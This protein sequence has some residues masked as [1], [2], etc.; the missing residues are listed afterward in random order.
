MLS[1]QDEAFIRLAIERGALAP[2]AL[3]QLAGAPPSHQSAVQI[4]VDQGWLSSLE[5][6]G[7]LREVMSL[8]FGCPTCG[9]RTSHDG[10]ASR[11]SFACPCGGGLAPLPTQRTSSGSFPLPGPDA[12]RGPADSDFVRQAFGS[13]RF[14]APSELAPGQVL[15]GYH[16]QRELGRGA[17]GVVFLARR[18]GLE[19]EFAIKVLLDDT[20]PDAETIARFE[21]EAAIGSKLR[22]P[23]VIS[24]YDV[25]RIQDCLYYAMEYSPGQD[26]KAVLRERGR[27]PWEEGAE[28]CR[29]LA[30]TLAH[31]HDRSVIHRDLKP[32]NIIL[33]TELNRPRVTDFGLAR[34]RTL[35]QTMTATGDWL[36]TPYYMSPEQFRG[37]T[38]LDHRADIYALGTILFEVLT[39]ERPYV[40]K[41]AQELMELVLDGQPP[42]P[43]SRV[44]DLPVGLDHVVSRAMESDPE[45][46]YP[47]ARE[48]AADL[49]AVL[50]GRRLGPQRTRLAAG[51]FL[52]AAALFA[53]TAFVYS[54]RGRAAPPTPVASAPKPGASPKASPEPTPSTP[55]GY[56]WA[57]L[58]ADWKTWTGDLDL[59]GLRKVQP[60]LPAD[61]L[62]A[63]EATR[64]LNLAARRGAPWSDLKSILKRARASEDWVA[65]QSRLD[66]LEVRLLLARGRSRRALEVLGK[67]RSPQALWLRALAH[68][69]AGDQVRAPDLL[70]RLAKGD[71]P[72]SSLA[73]ARL[74]GA[75]EDSQRVLALI[76]AGGEVPESKLELAESLQASGDGLRARK[77]LDA[78]LARS[79]PSPR[80]LRLKGDLAL[81]LGEVTTALNA[82][83]ASARLLE[84][85]TDLGL[86]ERRGAALLRAKRNSDAAELLTASIP[87]ARVDEELSSAEVRFL[88]LRGLARQ[89]LGAKEEARLDWARAGRAAEDV[90]R[91]ALPAS[92]SQEE[93]EGFNAALDA[94][95]ASLLSEEERLDTQT[96]FKAFADMMASAQLG[97]PWHNV[98][99]LGSLPP[100]TLER[101]P[102]PSG[103]S[104]TQRDLMVATRAAVEGKSWEDILFYLS[105]ALE[106]ETAKAQVRATWMRLARGRACEVEA[107]ARRL[108]DDPSRYGLSGDEASFA[109]AEVAWFQGLAGEALKGFETLRESGERQTKPGPFALLASAH[110]ALLT[111]Q[112]V[113]AERMGQ[114]LGEKHQDARGFALAGL[115]ALALNKRE[116][117]AKNQR[118]AYALLGASDYRVLAL[119]GALAAGSAPVVIMG[120]GGGNHGAQA[121]ANLVLGG[122]P[123]ELLAL[124]V[125]AESDND[126]LRGFFGR[127]LAS[128]K[129]LEVAEVK[130]F[131]G[132]S[133]VRLK[134]EKTRCL[135]IWRAARE[136]DSS[137]PLPKHYLSAYAEAYGS[138]EG[139]KGLR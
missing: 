45:D 50:A 94:P 36:G 11:P 39:G 100:K 73:K 118:V 135:S 20:T 15:G 138:E 91:G 81:A 101:Y 80:A 27:L 89:R 85:D 67:R 78:Y 56:D 126:T 19:R 53:T 65:F 122:R 106:T 7:L 125:L 71:G 137:L 107:V 76:E 102:V 127:H 17:N 121:R 9:W 74:V 6:T 119:R 57:P 30:E 88:V 69:A 87:I 92:A 96:A 114:S 46:R 58:L 48:M 1:A 136:L 38:D 93:E 113:Q 59:A 129:G 111:G 29:Q 41:S 90:A 14:R 98:Q 79:G 120:A 43:R 47:D 109:R 2:G 83:E 35:A 5:A 117:A 77:A 104:Q 66:L 99:P 124:R 61:R 97:G 25:G 131:L 70:A 112:F 116:E 42:S 115:A 64:E 95:E 37:E 23:G 33:D 34:D 16:L 4:V 31:C 44:P 21:L 132:Y 60:P 139:L 133:W 13:T 108:A 51:A 54:Q 84:Q 49:A 22:D 24:V 68:E 62:A 63:L 12:S 32:G 110:A 134:K 75:S 52:A 3:P 103:A 82:F 18:P 28:L 10:L 8:S 86:V 26:L 128:L 130:H 72:E 123:A 40:A 55:R 105:R